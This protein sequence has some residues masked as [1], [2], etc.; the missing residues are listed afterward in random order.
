MGGWVGSALLLA[1]SCER[2]SAGSSEGQAAG[3]CNVHKEPRWRPTCGEVE[4]R[5]WKCWE[6]G[7]RRQLNQSRRAACA[8][9]VDCV[10]CWL[11]IIAPPPPSV[12]WLDP[13]CVSP[14]RGRRRWRV[15]VEFRVSAVLPAR[16][17]HRTC[18][19]RAW[20]PGEAPYVYASPQELPDTSGG[21]KSLHSSQ[22]LPASLPLGDSH[23]RSHTRSERKS[24][25]TRVHRQSCRGQSS[26]TKTH[27]S[28]KVSPCSKKVY[29]G[30]SRLHFSSVFFF[31]WN[32]TA[33][34][35]WTRWW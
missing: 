3:W 1:A 13:L 23:T 25:N 14:Q 6:A 17:S 2:S 31:M 16:V 4:H 29:L 12:W 26:T 35:R 30:R 20:T 9:S 19:G 7:P 32:V 11:I 18:A 21:E 33:A 34:C 15:C 5:G 22:C 8:R 10:V 24:E 27:R 28:E